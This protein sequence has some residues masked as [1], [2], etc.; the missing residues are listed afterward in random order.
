MESIGVLM[1]IPMNSYL[2][3]EL[4]KCFNLFKLWTLP[5]KTRFIK[6][7]AESIR[8]IIENSF[9]GTGADA[10]TIS[11]FPNLEIVSSFS[12]GMDK[13][14]L[15]LC[16]E[17]GIRVTN[18]PDV[19][20]N[21]VSDLAIGLMLAGLRRLCESNRYVRASKWKKG[22]YKLTAMVFFHYAYLV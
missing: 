6:E 2:E 5:N 13:V 11:T 14:G 15:K 3:T 9:S 7:N 1:P 19:L 17:K 18:T 10:N 20:T 16:K 12:V 22:D 4:K 8:A 21:D